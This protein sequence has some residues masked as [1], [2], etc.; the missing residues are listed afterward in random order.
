MAPRLVLAVAADGEI[1]LA[2]WNELDL[3]AATWTIPA[4]RMKAGKKHTVPLPPA[5]L[6]VFRRA[7]ELRMAG[8]DLVFPGLKRGKPLSDMTLL[9]I[10]RDMKLDATVH[11][12]RSAFRD[13]CAEETSIPGEV[14]E[15]AL[16]HA[17]PNKV[18]AAY[19]RTDFFEKRRKLM[20]A[21]NGFCSA[22][23]VSVVRRVS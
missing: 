6:R 21:W 2:R 23:S 12:F 22:A 4:E 7:A 16:A 18:E 11:G 13:W 1:R 14:A 15:A 19:R 3:E 17:I 9:K 5:A 20:D 10:L 8:T